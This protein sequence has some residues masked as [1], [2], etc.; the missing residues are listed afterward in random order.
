MSLSINTNVSSLLAQRSLNANNRQT[1]KLI[2]QL[3]SGSR[4]NSAQDDA[5][6]LAISVGLVSQ[7]ASTNQAV[8]NGDDALNVVDTSDAALNQTGDIL[9]Q[10]RQLAIQAGDG[11][12]SPADRSAIQDQSASLTSELDRIANGTEYNGTALLNGNASLGFQVGTDGNPA[13][14]QIDVTTSDV[15]VNAL[16][17]NN[18]NLST[19]GAAAGALAGIDNAISV[20]SSARATLGAQAERVSSAIASASQSSISLAAA[21][22]RIADV[23]VAQATSD[24]ASNLIVGQAG[25][26]VLAQANQN[27]GAALRLLAA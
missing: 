14:S 11:A 15:S 22:S 6:A 20:A 5:A 25:V 24:L 8:D 1:P 13:N 26:S 12:L 23:D 4:V 19:P 2:N 3:S 18:L 7:L 9:G 21:N 17:L 10:L 16:G 27:H